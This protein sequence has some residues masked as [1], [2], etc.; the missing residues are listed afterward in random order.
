MIE[1]IY[2]SAA[3]GPM[4]EAELRSLLAR[5]R[6]NNEAAGLTGLLLHDR[7]SFLQVLEGEALAVKT[8]FTKIAKDPRHA[9]VTTLR[10][11]PIRERAFD[12][13]SMGFV[14]LEGGVR[15]SP[16]FSELLSP[17][18]S[19]Q[20][21]LASREHAAARQILLAFRDGRFRSFVDT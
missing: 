15:G 17:A 8:L 3:V 21:F 14:S 13:W 1:L 18:F 2:A 19:V 16:G 10:E 9:R 12:R 11:D 7:G 4:P 6:V 5:S 20:S